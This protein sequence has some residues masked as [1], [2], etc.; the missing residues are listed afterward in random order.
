M[1]SHSRR[2]PQQ[3]GHARSP[4]GGSAECVAQAAGQSR[5]AVLRRRGGH[6]RGQRHLTQ[7]S[8]SIRDGWRFRGTGQAGSPK[9]GPEPGTTGHRP[10][11]VHF[12]VA[13]QSA[14]NWWRMGLGP[15]PQTQAQPTLPPVLACG[16]KAVVAANALLRA[17]RA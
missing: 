17:M 11:A 4:G 14:G 8:G 16:Q 7:V 6:R 2:Q 3:R 12:A 13:L 10:W 15:D 5:R 9:G 1:R